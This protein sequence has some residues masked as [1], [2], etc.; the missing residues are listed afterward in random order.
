MTL[1]TYSPRTQLQ[2]NFDS[3]IDNFFNVDRHIENDY[4]LN[5]KIDIIENEKSYI[6]T[7]DLPGINKKD[8]ELYISNDI[9]TISGERKSIDKNYPYN[10]HNKINYGS[11]S[12][13]FYLPENTNTNKI[14]AKMKDG[15]LVVTMHKLKIISVDIKKISIK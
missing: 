14:D 9:I 10:I 12:K 5:P 3:W 8:I 4:H 15:V 1:I 13:S 6:I 7:A 2:S 11:F